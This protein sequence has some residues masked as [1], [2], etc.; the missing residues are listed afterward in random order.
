MW[1][2]GPWLTVFFFPKFFLLKKKSKR[3]ERNPP[4]TSD[5][6]ESERTKGTKPLSIVINAITIIS[7]LT[8]HI[9]S[10]QH[11]CYT[12]RVNIS[13]FPWL[14]L[15]QQ[16]TQTHQLTPAHSQWGVSF[17]FFSNLFKKRLEFVPWL[18]HNCH[19]I[20]SKSDM[21]SA[22]KICTVQVWFCQQLQRETSQN[23]F[24]FPHSLCVYCNATRV[25]TDC[26]IQNVYISNGCHIFLI[27]PY[28]CASLFQSTN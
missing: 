25:W 21:N 24:T 12:T 7:C 2:L 1:D 11:F 19:G 22:G 15:S 23:K 16:S 20:F 4:I 3:C 13:R 8:T 27:S 5:L 14:W 18:L 9:L 26:V 17:P 10:T 6:K 28:W